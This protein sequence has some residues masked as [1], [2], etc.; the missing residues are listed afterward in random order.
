MKNSPAFSP[1]SVVGTTRGDIDMFDWVDGLRGL[2]PRI[3]RP[4]VPKGAPLIVSGW[5]VDPTCDEPPAAVAILIDDGPAM[6]AETG[7]DRSDVRAELGP[8]TAQDIGF[9]AVLPIEGLT[10]GGHQIHAYVLAAD[11]AWYDAAHWSF[12]VYSS[13]DP[14]LGAG[15]GKARLYLDNVIDVPLAGPRG[16]LDGVV[17]V[18]DIALVTGWAIDHDRGWSPAGVCAIDETGRAWSAPCDMPRPDVR[19]SIGAAADNLGFEIPI[20]TDALGRGRHRFKIQAFDAAGRRYGRSLEATFDVAAEMRPFPGFARCTD[21]RVDAMVLLAG[22]GRPPTLLGPRV[23]PE[24][25]RGE[26]WSME[27]WALVGEEPPAQIFLELHRPGVVT[28]PSRYQAI[29]GFQPKR[30]PRDLPAPFS[31]DAWF[32]CA[33]DTANITPGMYGLRVAVVRAGRRF[34]ARGELGSVRVVEPAGS[35]GAARRL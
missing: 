8:E 3:G 23:V 13:V 29:S 24:W 19:A 15:P 26:V 1:R 17:P 2:F 30:P 21:D 9:R 32:A 22:S 27:G 18:G 14:A 16:P 6:Q 4:R 28:P 31:D 10:P 20:P 12:W 33:I 34:Y 25:E 35:P 11:G 5:A 7:L